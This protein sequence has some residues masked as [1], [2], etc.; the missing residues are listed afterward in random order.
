MNGWEFFNNLFVTWQGWAGMIVAAISLL[1]VNASRAASSG[2][3]FEG[4]CPIE[5]VDAP[6]EDKNE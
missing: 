3:P 1:I 4:K 6:G 5:F 2:C